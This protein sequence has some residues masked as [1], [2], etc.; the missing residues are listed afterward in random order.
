MSNFWGAVQISLHFFASSGNSIGTGR[1]SPQETD[2]SRIKI[3]ANRL[4]SP[5]QTPESA[6]NDRKIIRAEKVMNAS[7]YKNIDTL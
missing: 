7:D 2:F 3:G 4:L 5:P 1:I 6:L